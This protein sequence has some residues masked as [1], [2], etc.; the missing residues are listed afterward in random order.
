MLEG[1]VVIDHSIEKAMYSPHYL[2][3]A[4]KQK[5][6]NNYKGTA[7]LELHKY[8]NTFGAIPRYKWENTL[9]AKRGS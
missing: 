8:H 9:P 1:R 6:I 2:L 5:H 7:A 4:C 3:N